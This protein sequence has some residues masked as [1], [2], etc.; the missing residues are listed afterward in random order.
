MLAFTVPRSV[1]GGTITE[2]VPANATSATLKPAGM[3]SRNA[4]APVCA[5]DSLEGLTS[6]AS[7]DFDTS[8]TTTTVARSRGTSV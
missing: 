4:F 1:V 2:D 8:M 7:M 5:A 3:M 6:V